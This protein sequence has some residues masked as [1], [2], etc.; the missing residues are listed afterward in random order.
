VSL[1]YRL[2]GLLIVAC[3][4]AFCRGAFLLWPSAF[5]GTLGSLALVVAQVALAVVAGVLGVLNVAAGAVVLLR[6]ARA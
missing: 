6:P 3:G 5:D 4:V 1:P 2:L